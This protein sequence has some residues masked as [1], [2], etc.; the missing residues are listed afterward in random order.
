MYMTCVH[1]VLVTFLEKTED[2]EKEEK[3]TIYLDN[4]SVNFQAVPYQLKSELFIN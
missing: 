2:S 3:Q 4:F 1:Q